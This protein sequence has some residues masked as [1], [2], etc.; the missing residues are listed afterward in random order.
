MNSFVSPYLCRTMHGPNVDIGNFS[1]AGKRQ[2]RYEHG[3]DIAWLEH[4]RRVVLFADMFMDFMLH[5]G[6]GIAR[7]NTED[8]N[9]VRINFESKCIRQAFKCMFGSTVCGYAFLSTKRYT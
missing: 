9:A 1:R 2:S 3:G 4:G 7:K 5:G 6:V 8:S